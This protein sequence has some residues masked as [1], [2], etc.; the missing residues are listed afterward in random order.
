MSDE[1]IPITCE[2]CQARLRVKPGVFKIMKAVRC[3]KCGASITLAPFAPKPGAPAAAPAAPAPEPAPAPAPAPIPVAEPPAPTPAEPVAAAAPP[4]PPPPA[5]PP[6]APPSTP[7]PELE[8]LHRRIAILERDLAEAEARVTDLQQLWQSK[9]IEVREMADRLRHAEKTA[10]QAVAL[11]DAF[12]GRIK[13]ELS[14]HLLKERDASLTRFAELERKL[15]SL[16]PE[17]R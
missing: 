11:R 3:T 2:K 12:L 10:D 16:S 9:E 4:P 17:P 13:D 15:L 7:A 6:P 1:L 8:A 5:T 14:L